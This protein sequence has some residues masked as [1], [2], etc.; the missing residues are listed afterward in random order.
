MTN[1]NA[2]GHRVSGMAVEAFTAAPEPCPD[3]ILWECQWEGLWLD[4]FS[5]RLKI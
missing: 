2:T 5:G 3:T 4:A 1:K